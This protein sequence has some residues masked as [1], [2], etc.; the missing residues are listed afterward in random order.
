MLGRSLRAGFPLQVLAFL[1]FRAKRRIFTAAAGFPLQSLT[2]IQHFVYLEI[3]M[4]VT[5]QLNRTIEFNFPPQRIISLVPSQSELIWYLGLHK[6][7]VGITKFCIHPKEMFKA[8]TH[9]GGTKKIK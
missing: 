7:L 1:S 4:Q 6:E 3:T 9:V 5:D 8:I 2:Q